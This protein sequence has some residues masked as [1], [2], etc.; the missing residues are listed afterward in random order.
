MTRSEIRFTAVDP[1]GAWSRAS[2]AAAFD[3]PGG[4]RHLHSCSC[5]KDRSLTRCHTH[6]GRATG[7][8]VSGDDGLV[9]LTD[10][11]IA[12]SAVGTD[13]DRYP[14]NGLSRSLPGFGSRGRR[15]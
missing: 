1:A 3:A 13:D 10:V 8:R 14:P 9:K 15:G 12:R 11:G 4:S 2:F 5:R 7:E 6:P